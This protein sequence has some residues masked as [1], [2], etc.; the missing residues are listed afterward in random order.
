MSDSKTKQ[1]AVAR[2][3]VLGKLVLN[4]LIHMSQDARYDRNVLLWMQDRYAQQAMVENM[5]LLIDV[6][7]K[8]QKE[9]VSQEEMQRERIEVLEGLTRKTYAEEKEK[10]RGADLNGYLDA[11]TTF[12][13]AESV[14][15]G[16]HLKDVAEEI[17]KALPNGEK[18]DLDRISRTIY[19]VGSKM[20][21][22]QESLGKINQPAAQAVADLMQS[23]MKQINFTE[24]TNHEVPIG[25]EL[26]KAIEKIAEEPS[27]YI[28]FTD[29]KNLAMPTFDVWDFEPEQRSL[30]M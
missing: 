6:V 30:G 5:T 12:F 21:A 14:R 27:R 26:L 24:V 4:D 9:G 17:A 22:A 7:R 19:G 16:S 23:S 1:P 25:R 8:G 28:N 3:P 10:G 18:P 11:A 20:S 15:Y 29:P 13:E 2:E